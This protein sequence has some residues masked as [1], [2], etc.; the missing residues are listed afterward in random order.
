MELSTNKVIA[1]SRRLQMLMAQSL[2]AYEA[3]E[4]TREEMTFEVTKLMLQEVL[5]ELRTEKEREE[6]VRKDK[7]WEE[8]NKAHAEMSKGGTP[9]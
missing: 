7:A 8:T 5:D 9:T 1:I 6:Q 3:K 4:L 2:S